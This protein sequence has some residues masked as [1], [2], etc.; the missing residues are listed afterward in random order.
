MA[1]KKIL[2]S[3]NGQ[4]NFKKKN[5]PNLSS[6]QKKTFQMGLKQLGCLRPFKKIKIKYGNDLKTKEFSH[7]LF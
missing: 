5:L 3:C 7:E 6:V 1:L 4:P 2:T